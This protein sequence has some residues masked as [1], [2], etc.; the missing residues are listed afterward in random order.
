MKVIEK[1]EIVRSRHGRDCR[2]LYGW[3]RYP[4]FEPRVV[5]QASGGEKTSRD[6]EMER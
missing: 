2:W 5:R 3:G 1:G 6:H 4:A